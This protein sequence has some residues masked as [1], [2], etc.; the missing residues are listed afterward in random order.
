MS[1]LDVKTQ[2][3][4]RITIKIVSSLTIHTNLQTYGP[5]GEER[6]MKFTS[7]EGSRVIGFYGRAGN[8]LDS[9]GV[10]TIPDV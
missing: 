4:T 7:D 5:F 9:L 6:G 3:S 10:V 1:E 8:M 2:N